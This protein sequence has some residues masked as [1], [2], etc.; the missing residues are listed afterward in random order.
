[1]ASNGYPTLARGLKE[2]YGRGDLRGVVKLYD[3]AMEEDMK[4]RAA[5]GDGRAADW[6]DGVLEK[7]AVFELMQKY[8]IERTRRLIQL[9]QQSEILILRR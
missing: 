8:G 4:R 9:V 2:L 7:D 5:A 6:L 1:L 3:F